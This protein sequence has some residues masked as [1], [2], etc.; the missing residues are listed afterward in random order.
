M[1]DFLL[2]NM[3]GKITDFFFFL[4]YLEALIMKSWEWIWG[5]WIQKGIV[6]STKTVAL[7][8]SVN[9]LLSSQIE[10]TYVVS[11]ICYFLQVKYGENGFGDFLII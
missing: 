7:K 4:A 5:F 3:E 10:C 11:R 8:S 9:Y 1:F 2:E 6:A